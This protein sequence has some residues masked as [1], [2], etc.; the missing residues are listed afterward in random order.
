ML[1]LIFFIL[2]LG[3][4]FCGDYKSYGMAAIYKWK[5]WLSLITK[6]DNRPVESESKIK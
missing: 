3:I 4:I 2:S 1:D 6:R 5:E